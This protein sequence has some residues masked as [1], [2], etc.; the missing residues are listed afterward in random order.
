MDTE[1]FSCEKRVEASQK[2][3]IRVSRK[4]S[5]TLIETKQTRYATID[6]KEKEDAFL[7]DI[8][9]KIAS[10]LIPIEETLHETRA[11]W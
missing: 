8:T 9:P 1:P 4:P 11:S 3:R 6:F 10:R 2:S 5:T 7:I